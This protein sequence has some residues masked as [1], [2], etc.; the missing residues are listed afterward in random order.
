MP[1]SVCE[2]QCCWHS[3]QKQ[4]REHQCT[5]NPHPFSPG[6]SPGLPTWSI[7]PWSVVQRAEGSILE[8]TQSADMQNY[9]PALCLFPHFRVHIILTRGRK[10]PGIYLWLL[11]ELQG[12]AHRCPCDSAL[13]ANRSQGTKPPQELLQVCRGPGNTDSR[14]FSSPGD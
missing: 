2:Q 12:M 11:T 7:S 5:A 10:S 14:A 4:S 9:L 6:R 3:Q 8:L 1:V 13:H